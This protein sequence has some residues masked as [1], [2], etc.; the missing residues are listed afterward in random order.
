M[1][2]I[3]CNTDNTLKDRTGNSGRCKR[4]SHRFV[5]EPTTMGKL[6]ITDPKF[7]KTIDDLSA[8]GS[9]FFTQDQLSYFLDKRL[10]RSATS[11]LALAMFGYFFTTLFLTGLLG[12]FATIFV[13]GI[14]GSMDMKFHPAFFFV[15]INLA[16]HAVEIGG[17]CKKST[18]KQVDNH[19]R[20]SAPKRLCVL[21]FTIL[22]VGIPVTLFIVPTFILFVTVVCLG[23]GAI[24]F[25]RRQLARPT[26]SQELLFR[27]EDLENWLNSWRVANG[28]VNQLLPPAISQAG[29]A[30]VNPDVTA[31]SFDRLVVCERDDVAQMLI[32]NNFHFENNCAILS[33]GGYPQ[34]IFDVTMQ[35]LRRNPDLKVYLLHDCTISGMGMLQQL[36]QSD[37]W[38]KDSN[39]T[40]IDV[41]L[42][43]RQVML[44][45]DVFI[46]T[47][48]PIEASNPAKQANLAQLPGLGPDEVTW[49][50]AGNYVELTSF[51][52]QQLI[53]VLNRG[54]A[55]TRDLL[56]DNDSGV[57]YYDGGI[58]STESFG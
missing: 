34:N 58:Y 22:L 13:G 51:T 50:A 6:K 14:A 47:A 3:Q 24:Y 39:I 54:I 25:G 20:R 5:F 26:I 32:A 4:C 16:M 18:S 19:T 8:N 43:P 31:Y 29:T 49:L 11:S 52:P 46:R 56:V 55:G 17:L 45:K 28:G 9:L 33:I 21:G 35:M 53:Q 15:M 36:Q 57:G 40:M 44:A 30:T 2:C 42:T 23:V 7:K 37:L 1:K 41:G 12:T 10:R 38:F 48:S 27:Y